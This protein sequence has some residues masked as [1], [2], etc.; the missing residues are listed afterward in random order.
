MA[1][2][3]ALPRMLSKVHPQTK[4]PWIAVIAT[5]LVTIAVISLSRGNILLV[6]NV[7]V[8]NIFIV[9]SLV[10]FVLIWLR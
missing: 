1:K 2:G 8:F 7:S 4:T 6:A 9:Y 10:N 5:M 3:G